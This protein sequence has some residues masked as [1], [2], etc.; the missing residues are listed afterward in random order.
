MPHMKKFKKI[1]K[2]EKVLLGL[3]S[4]FY[5]WLWLNEVYKW[6]FDD[7]KPVIG[8]GAFLPF[9]SSLLLLLVVNLILII[10]KSKSIK[11]VRTVS[12][13]GLVLA[14]RIS[15]ES[16]IVNYSFERQLYIYVI[17]ILQILALLIPLLKNIKIGLTTKYIT[18]LIGVILLICTTT[19]IHI[20]DTFS[21]RITGVY[22]N[23]F[24]WGFYTKIPNADLFTFK[25][26]KRH[27]ATDSTG[28]V[29]MI[30][31]EDMGIKRLII[32]EDADAVGELHP[33]R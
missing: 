32:E 21:I 18:I 5:L 27:I 9:Y 17:G 4:F 28:R 20:N 1:L 13:C 30:M 33:T 10:L 26:L 7:P 24:G 25:L 15:L 19:I 14:Y 22:Y 23:Q 3:L 2:N 29:Y 16:P 12:M 11:A 6:V 31:V 8:K